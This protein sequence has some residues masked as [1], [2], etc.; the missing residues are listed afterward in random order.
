MAKYI[1]GA[2]LNSTINQTYLQFG[3]LPINSIIHKKKRGKRA[4][5]NRV[6]YIQI[7]RTPG[8]VIIIRPARR[9]HTPVVA[10]SQLT[11]TSYTHGVI[12]HVH[13]RIRQ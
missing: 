9:A 8:G 1:I 10:G 13:P 2:F 3:V 4:I 6:G 5:Y 12:K 11:S 7:D